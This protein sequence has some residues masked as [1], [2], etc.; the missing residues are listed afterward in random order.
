[1]LGFACSF[2][3]DRIGLAEPGPVW[4]RKTMN[5]AFIRMLTGEKPYDIFRTENRTCN[6]GK[7]LQTEMSW[8]G[9]SEYLR[10]GQEGFQDDRRNVDYRQ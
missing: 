6:F 9:F 1:M 5:V 10:Q 8:T 2:A 4:I 3:C 7:S